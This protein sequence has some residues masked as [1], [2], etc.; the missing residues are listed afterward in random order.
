MGIIERKIRDR[1][2]RT[3][4]IID[5]AKS[6]FITKGFN[7]ATMNDI[8][9]MSDLSRRTLYLYFH[10]KEEIL[11]TIAV[12]TL[13]KLVKE[14]KADNRP[15][16]TGLNQLLLI[17]NK[18]RHLFLTDAGSFEFVPNFTSCVYSL[19][20]DNDIVNKC[21][22]IVQ[23]ISNLVCEK[24]EIGVKD[25]SIRPVENVKKTAAFVISIMHSCIQTIQSDNGLLKIA[26]KIE[27][28]DFLD[29]AVE[30]IVNY[31]TKGLKPV[32]NF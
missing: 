29:E 7:K 28:S 19:G 2:K 6:I 26:L 8:A 9:N 31:L 11:L 5:G 1:Q 30:V 24:L 4:E 32:S 3:K 23:D 15:E 22:L 14:I 10:N 27:P 17:A 18:Y 21:T 25:G 12:N 20:V 16:D 13:E